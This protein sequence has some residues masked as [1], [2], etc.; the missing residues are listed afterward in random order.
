MATKKSTT[1]TK[2]KESA[3]KSKLGAE[4]IRLRAEQIYNARV[5]RGESGDAL[6]DWLQAEKEL[7]G[8]N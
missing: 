2:K 4:D 6:S 3:P 1:T 7:S 5:N 8:V